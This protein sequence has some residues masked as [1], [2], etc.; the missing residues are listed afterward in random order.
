MSSTL[1]TAGLWREEVSVNRKLQRLP[2][3]SQR[4]IRGQTLG[5][6]AVVLI[7][8]IGVAGMLIDSGIIS[9]SRRQAQRAADAAAQAAAFELITGNYSTR[10]E[11][12]YAAANQYA[13]MN[14][15]S[16]N[17]CV[18]V[19]SP[20]AASSN[21]RYAGTNG[22]VRVEVTR[23]TD[24]TLMR[25]LLLKPT[26]NVRATAT[27]MGVPQP[28]GHTILLLHPS[29]SGSLFINGNGS[30]SVPNGT[31]YVDSAASDAV[32]LNGNAWLRAITLSIVGGQSSVGNSSI[33]ATIV[34]GAPVLADPLA[35]LPA[36]VLSDY[37][38]SLNSGGTAANP[39]TRSYSGNVQVTINPGIYWG[40]IKV[41]AN[42]IVHMNPGR[43]IM[44]G[45][46]ITVS[47]N[48]KVDGT[49]VFIYNTQDPQNPNGAGAYA[50]VSVTG[51]GYTALGAR[52]AET[53][54]TYKGVL[55]FNDRASTT[56]VTVHGNGG[57]N[58]DPPYGGF[59]YNKNG[60]AIL[61]GNGTYG[62]LGI[63]ARRMQV[64]GNGSFTALDPSR[65]PDTKTVRLVE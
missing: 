16:T 30:L 31:I 14:G 39:A 36:P 47:G 43:Y 25:L 65:T 33:F 6:V 63:I 20:P 2:A 9:G 55:L 27:A 32:T 26:V 50:P 15:I 38:T 45:G 40:G 22:A 62:A 3:P 23:P 52:T 51:N 57:N 44:A 11:R 41:S 56:S 64:S 12:M 60:D 34:T 42:A 49:D 4:A 1:D 10:T 18:L 17:G 61:T 35:S 19:E 8:M 28:F 37:P 59:I 13:S 29:A 46:G 21:S 53:D 54:S 7:A 58:G 48:G 24:V 5:V